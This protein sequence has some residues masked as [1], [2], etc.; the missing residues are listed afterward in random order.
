MKIE[1]FRAVEQDLSLMQRLFYQTVTTYGSAVFTKSEIK[2]YSQLASDTSYWLD[3]FETEY[4][5]N[6][7][8]NGEII[9]SVFMNAKG[10]I[11]YIFINRNYHGLGVASK[12][13]N[14]VEEI[15]R[16]DKIITLTTSINKQTR[17]FFE[18]KGFQIIK[19]AVRVSGGEEVITYSGIKHL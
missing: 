6:A 12:L 13:Y 11:E 7:K 5:Y 15:A 18:S 19:N 4:I 3:K 9:G 2:Q 1:V 17:S 10:H 8:L 16:E 14:T